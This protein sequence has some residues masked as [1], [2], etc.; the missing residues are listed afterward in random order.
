M[1]DAGVALSAAAISSAFPGTPATFVRD[2]TL[3]YVADRVDVDAHVMTT[4]GH[5]AREAIAAVCA[6]QCWGTLADVE[7]ITVHLDGVAYLVRMRC[8]PPVWAATVVGT[9]DSLP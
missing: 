7:R 1:D 3:T 2:V 6:A 4:H 9:V 5:S 8:E